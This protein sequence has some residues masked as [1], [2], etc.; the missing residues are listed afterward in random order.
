MS[1]I[2]P[3]QEAHSPGR[4][5]QPA[6]KRLNA[7]AGTA[8]GGHTGALMRLKCIRTNGTRLTKLSSLNFAA[9][10]PP[11]TIIN[12]PAATCAIRYQ[13]STHTAAITVCYC[14]RGQ[15]MASDPTTSYVLSIICHCRF[16]YAHMACT[17]E[18]FILRGGGEHIKCEPC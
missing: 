8:L 9:S 14:S 1:T 15:R 10:A 16:E 11:P 7:P 4:G 13:R 12:A 3:V 5:Q 18:A 17:F 6:G 2:A